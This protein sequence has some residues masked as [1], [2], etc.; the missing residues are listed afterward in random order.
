M[1]IIFKVASLFSPRSIDCIMNMTS[2]LL[3]LSARYCETPVT[4]LGRYFFTSQLRGL[5]YHKLVLSEKGNPHHMTFGGERLGDEEELTADI[6]LVNAP[7][8][9][10]KLLFHTDVGFAEAFME[11]DFVT[12]DMFILL[13]VLLANRQCE[14]VWV[15]SFVMSAFVL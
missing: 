15:A 8:F 7:A 9:F 10:S 11:G 2:S 13:K 6:R 5:K 1:I 14:E 4:A 12:T 3:N